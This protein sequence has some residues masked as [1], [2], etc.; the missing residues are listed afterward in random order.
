MLFIE[1]LLYIAIYNDKPKKNLLGLSNQLAIFLYQKCS[2]SY[3][4]K[5][6][7]IKRK[8]SYLANVRTEFRGNYYSY[9]FFYS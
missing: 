7:D 2:I 6:Y 4:H 5:I 3:F 9:L 8:D 1:K